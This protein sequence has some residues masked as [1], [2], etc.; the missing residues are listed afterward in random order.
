M[1]QG[2]HDQGVHEGDLLLAV[3][4]QLKVP[5]TTIA[6]QAELGQL[7]GQSESVDHASIRTQAAAALTLVDSYMLGLEVLRGQMQLELEPVS[8]SSMLV[9]TAHDLYRFARHYGVEL[10][11]QTAGRYGPVM[12]NSRGLKAALL[13][14]GFNL[15]EAEAGGPA[16]RHRRVVLGLHRTPQGIVTGMYGK[17][18]GLTAEGWRTARQLAGQA[19]QP[20]TVIG[21]GSTAGLFVA[22]ALLR[23]MNSQLRVGQYQHQRGLAATFQPSQ[24]LRF[25]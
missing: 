21:T 3:A 23:S 18:D 12:S 16:R 24:Q 9:D 13:S 7:T 4:E 10:E 19:R 2:G 20:L 11:M 14:L 25:V 17:Y 22:D 1:G 8:V 15:I 5:L 6:R